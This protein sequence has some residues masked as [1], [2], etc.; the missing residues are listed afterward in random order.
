MSREAQVRFCER[1]GVRFP[2]PTL[3][4]V[5]CRSKGQA[6]AALARLT[7]LLADLGLEPKAAKTRIV[8]LTVGGEGVDFLGFHHRL[9]RSRATRGT[10]TVVYLARWPSRK[11]EQHARDRIQF[12][13]MRARL[14]APVEQV[15]QEINL[16]LRGW[17]GYFRYGN[18]AR[19]FDKI[20][21]YAL[22]R[23]ALFIAKRHNRGR[24]RGFAQIYRSPGALGLISLNG[25]VVAP[26]PNRA[27]RAPA[28]H[29][30]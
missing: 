30:R 18:S 28:E 20:R 4:L 12:M 25:I 10:G 6:V 9:V 23:L 7:A 1:R 14:A 26:R 13:T 27:W 19:S 2:P 21:R 22:M 29:R 24:A 3:P 8:H 15:V 5:M 16:F 11:A 17:A